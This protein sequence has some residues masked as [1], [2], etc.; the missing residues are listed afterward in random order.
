MEDGESPPDRRL[1]LYAEDA[2]TRASAG[3]LLCDAMNV[4]STEQHEHLV[5]VTSLAQT[6]VMTSL[7]EIVSVVPLPAVARA[8]T[9]RV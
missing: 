4:S 5:E 8:V 1:S 6:A 3:A 9:I 2:D 7:T